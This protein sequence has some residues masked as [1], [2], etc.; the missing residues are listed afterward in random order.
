M[1]QVGGGLGRFLGQQLESLCRE[2]AVAADGRGFDLADLQ[3]ELAAQAAVVEDTLA[4]VD[5][6]DDLD[7]LG[8]RIGPVVE[9]VEHAG[10][11][12]GRLF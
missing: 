5:G 1:F 3:G 12:A 10:G 9:D 7:R 6:A 2:D 4:T 11:R 8:F